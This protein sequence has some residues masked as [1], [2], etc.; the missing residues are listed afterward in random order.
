MDVGEGD[1]TCEMVRFEPVPIFIIEL[2][3]KNMPFESKVHIL[4]ELV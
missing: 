2:S 3:G 1:E 4:F